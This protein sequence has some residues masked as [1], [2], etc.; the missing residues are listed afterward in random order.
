VKLK[1]AQEDQKRT[2]TLGKSGE[3]RIANMKDELDLLTKS[4]TKAQIEMRKM[5]REGYSEEQIRE[6]GRLQEEIDKLNGKK[7]SG[8]GKTEGKNPALMMGTKE[9]NE[10]LFKG[11]NAQ[12]ASVAKEQLTVL[13]QIASGLKQRGEADHTQIP[14]IVAGVIG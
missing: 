5:A 1:K 3:N 2:E 12:G 14:K 8:S 7:E 11:V 6:V 9:A 13:K 4:A 10:L